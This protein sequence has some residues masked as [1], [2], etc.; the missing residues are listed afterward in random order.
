MSARLEIERVDIVE[1]RYFRVPE[2]GLGIN[3]C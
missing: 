3:P 2:L 1:L